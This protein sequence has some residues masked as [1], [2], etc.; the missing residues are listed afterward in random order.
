MATRAPVSG[1]GR[2]LRS[3]HKWYYNTA[4]FNKFGLMHDDLLDETPVVRE[5]IRRLPEKA[6][7]ERTYRMKVALDLSMKHRIL[8]ESQWIK[9]EEDVG[10]LQPYIH[11]VERELKEKAEWEKNL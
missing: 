9:Y 3:F 11:E 1:M 10:Y 7:N 2:I 4:G 8:P 5:A 6:Y